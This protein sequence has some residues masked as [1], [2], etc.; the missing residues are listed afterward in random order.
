MCDW[1]VARWGGL[2]DWCLDW[3]TEWLI[4][5]LINQAT[6]IAVRINL[7][8]HTDGGIGVDDNGNVLH[9]HVNWF[10]VVNNNIDGDVHAD[11]EDDGDED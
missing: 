8:V 2:M 1:A 3:L 11:V 9:V 7:E 10:V 6:E 5:R 4:D